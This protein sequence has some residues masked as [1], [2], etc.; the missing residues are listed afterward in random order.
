[1]SV[2]AKPPQ[3]A[4]HGPLWKQGDVLDRSEVIGTIGDFSPEI[5]YHMAART[6]RNGR[7]A[8]DYSIN[9]QGVAN[10]IEVLL[11]LRGLRL[12]IFASTMLVCRNGYQPKDEFDYCPSTAY[13]ES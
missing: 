3:H 5:V 10:V 13:G 2:A 12:A 11:A 1:M 4:E 6:D 9:T 8:D 7:T